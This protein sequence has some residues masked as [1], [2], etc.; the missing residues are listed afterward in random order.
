MWKLAARDFEDLLQVTTWFQ[1]HMSTAWLITYLQCALPVF[2]GL[3]HTQQDNTLLR[4]L[5]FDLTMW[6]AYAKLR[7]HT[8]TTLND[9]K[10][11]TSTLGRSVHIFIK[12]VCTQYNTTNLLYEMATHGRRAAAMATHGKRAAPVMAKKS[13]SARASYKKKK[14]T[15]T[16]KRKQLNLSTYKYHALG[17]YPNQIA[18]FGGTDN[19]STQMVR[20]FLQNTQN[21][22]ILVFNTGGTTTQ[23]DQI[24]LCMHQ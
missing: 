2:E 17:D 10:T 19:A 4:T 12:E 5:L 22:F 1:C 21:C 18:Q 24:S 14:K 3:L 11:L 9:F 8:D 23:D 16:S 20:G 15:R 13:D 6:H 7:L